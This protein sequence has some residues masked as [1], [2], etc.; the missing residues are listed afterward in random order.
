MQDCCPNPRILDI[1]LLSLPGRLNRWKKKYGGR[2]GKTVKERI[3]QRLWGG[4]AGRDYQETKKTDSVIVS[5]QTTTCIHLKNEQMKL[6]CK[7]C[8][9]EQISRKREGYQSDRKGRFE[10]SLSFRHNVWKLIV[11]RFV[12]IWLSILKKKIENCTHS[13]NNQDDNFY[14]T[15][16]IADFIFYSSNLTVI[17]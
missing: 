2:E 7:L 14:F 6:R 1:P 17:K 9:Y 11:F 15:I 10:V 8:K 5:K 16:Y 12:L 13:Q 4:I 3:E